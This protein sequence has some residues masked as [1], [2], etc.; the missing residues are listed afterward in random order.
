MPT[1][2]IDRL[3]F[4]QGGLCFFCQR[5]LPPADATVEH[6]VAVA[7]GGANADENCVA[8]CKALNTLLGRMSL[9]EKLRVVLNQ[10]GGFR[11][12]ND[13]ALAKAP[14][15]T[16]K[17]PTHQTAEERLAFV[18]ADLRKRGPTRPRTLKKLTSTISALFQKARPAHEVDSLIA[19]L[20]DQGMIS[21]DGTKVSYELPPEGA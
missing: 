8:C 4:A 14:A 3:L 15:K 11:C 7:N 13:R 2:L 19:K 16:G 18:V 12:P 21:I 20:Q 5:P 1:K 10:K 17:T 6:L 9:K